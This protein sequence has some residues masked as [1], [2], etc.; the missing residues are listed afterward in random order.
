MKHNTKR[1][2]KTIMLVVDSQ[3]PTYFYE[4]AMD[5]GLN[6]KKALWTQARFGKKQQLFLRDKDIVGKI[7]RQKFSFIIKGKFN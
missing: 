6:R 5:Q 2:K 7:T 1:Q 4:S 3:E